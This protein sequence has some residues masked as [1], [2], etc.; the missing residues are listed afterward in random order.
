MLLSM[1]HLRLLHVAEL[2]VPQPSSLE[3][4]AVGL[5]LLFA[6]GTFVVVVEPIALYLANELAAPLLNLPDAGATQL[7]LASIAQKSGH[8]MVTWGNLISSFW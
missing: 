8:E 3:S 6:P 2:P 5:L 1:A 4:N 7:L